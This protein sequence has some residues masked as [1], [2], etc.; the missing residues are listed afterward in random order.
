[1]GRLQTPQFPLSTPASMTRPFFHGRFAVLPLVVGQVLP[2]SDF[3]HPI[4]MVRIPAHG[5]T[6]SFT[7]RRGRPPPEF[8]FDRAA[9]DT[10]TPIVPGAVLY[11]AY[12]GRRFAHYFQEKSGELQVGV[13]TA[14]PD[15]V[16]FA[17]SA[18]TPNALYR[19]AMVADVNPIA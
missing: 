6:Q 15:V 11:E 10:L 5:I 12:Q 7:K 4:P 8:S 2:R 1:G 16:H 17:R 19:A 3:C 9:N 18:G 13:L 14:T